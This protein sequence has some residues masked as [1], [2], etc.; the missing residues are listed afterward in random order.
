MC[1]CIRIYTEH[2]HVNICVHCGVL[3]LVYEHVSAHV[4]ALWPHMAPLVHTDRMVVH[5]HMFSSGVKCPL[6]C[7]CS[8][9]HAGLRG[10]FDCCPGE[11]DPNLGSLDWILRVHGMELVAAGSGIDVVRRKHRGP[12]WLV[13]ASIASTGVTRCAPCDRRQ[14][15]CH[16][17]DAFISQH[18]GW[19]CQS[20]RDRVCG[21]GPCGDQP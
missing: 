15:A 14:A 9:R 7:K 1:A 8:S 16:R 5:G 2:V 11:G 10:G 13:W 4:C 19:R 20:L 17:E 3:Y 18:L 6:V 21:F 12:S